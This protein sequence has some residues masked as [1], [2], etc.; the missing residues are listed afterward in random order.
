MVPSLLSV[1]SSSNCQ[2]CKGNRGS[3][4]GA[5]GPPIC[6]CKNGKD[7]IKLIKGTF[8]DGNSTLCQNCSV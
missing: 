5:I 2:T 1:N 7:F 4:L 6:S 3:G 8:D